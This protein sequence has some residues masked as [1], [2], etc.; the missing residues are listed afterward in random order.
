MPY[1]D[2][3]MLKRTGGDASADTST[4]LCF[5]PPE[6]P[7][8]S[9]TVVT[10]TIGYKRDEDWILIKLTEGNEYTITVGGSQT[11]GELNDSVLKLMDSKGGLIDMNDDENGAKGKLGSELKFTPQAGTGTQVYYISVSGNTDNPGANNVGSYTVEVA[12][13]AVLP[14]GDGADIEG[15][16]MADKLTGSA[17]SEVHRWQ[18]RG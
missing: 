1:K 11:A 18:G 14:P 6:G 8:D 2:E 10:G 5:D 12:Q 3:S 4:Q 17:D 9:S 7:F 15:T 16:A 13:E